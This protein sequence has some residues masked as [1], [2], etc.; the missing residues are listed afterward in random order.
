VPLGN[1]GTLS[2]ELYAEVVLRDLGVLAQQGASPASGPYQPTWERVLQD[3]ELLH[4]LAAVPTGG[5]RC[6]PERSAAMTA[7]RPPD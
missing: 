4:R 6:H 1:G 7:E 2:A 5:P 3:I